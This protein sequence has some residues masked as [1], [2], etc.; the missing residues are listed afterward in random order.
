MLEYKGDP[1]KLIG[2]GVWVCVNEDTQ[3]YEKRK[4][5]EFSCRLCI[6]PG[7]RYFI[8]ELHVK[9][10]GG[11]THYVKPEY[12]YMRACDTPPRKAGGTKLRKLWLRL[13]ECDREISRL[14]AER[15]KLLREFR[16][17]KGEENGRS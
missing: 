5:V 9:D 2:R 3:D 10:R 1:T 11:K 15:V 16:N 8:P 17:A 7:Q 6:Q 13:S 4:I 12:I 14:Y